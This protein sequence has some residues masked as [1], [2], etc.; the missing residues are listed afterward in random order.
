MKTRTLPRSLVARLAVAL[1]ACV[2]GLSAGAAPYPVVNEVILAHPTGVGVSSPTQLAAIEVYT[3]ANPVAAGTLHVVIIGGS[4]GR[5]ANVGRIIMAY[6]LP[7]LAADAY[8]CVS[9]NRSGATTRT[10]LIV[11]GYTGP[12]SPP[13]G[14]GTDQIGRAHV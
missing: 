2:A 1:I 6:P 3:G 8:Y 14:G 13:F 7:A 5:N 9:S 11:E 10:I 12:V 4:S